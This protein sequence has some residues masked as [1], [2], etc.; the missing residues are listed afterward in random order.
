MQVEAEALST[1]VSDPPTPPP[2]PS[3]GYVH[4]I[5]TSPGDHCLEIQFP[6]GKSSKFWK[7]DGWKYGAP[8]RP[9]W[10]A[11]ACDRSKWKSVDSTEQGYD[12]WDSS[13]NA[14]DG[15]VVMTKYGYE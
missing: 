13:K 7:S 11:G 3:A 1:T 10:V 8:V 2:P 15:E 6:G 12:G 5:E 4:M 9:E 14:P